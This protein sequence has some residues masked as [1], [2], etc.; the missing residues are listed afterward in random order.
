MKKDEEVSSWVYSSVAD[1]AGDCDDAGEADDV[2]TGSFSLSFYFILNLNKLLLEKHRM[3]IPDYPYYHL[4][5]VANH[6]HLLTITPWNKELLKIV[7]YL[8]R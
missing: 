6:H 1:D 2:L 4:L 8:L 7:E 3:V 5:H